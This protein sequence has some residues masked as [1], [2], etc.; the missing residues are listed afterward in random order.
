MPAEVQRAVHLL[1]RSPESL[2]HR[3]IGKK[4]DGDRLFNGNNSHR[5]RHPSRE[6]R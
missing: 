4:D 5:Y 6:K 2:T 1:R 3:R